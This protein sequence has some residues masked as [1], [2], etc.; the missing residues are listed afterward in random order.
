MICYP[1][2]PCDGQSVNILNRPICL[3]AQFTGMMCLYYWEYCDVALVLVA[4][5][6]IIIIKPN[7]TSYHMIHRIVTF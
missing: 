6:G 4:T 2:E 7:I 3:A 5:V 1:M